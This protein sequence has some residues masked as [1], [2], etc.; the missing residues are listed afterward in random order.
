MKVIL[1]LLLSILMLTFITSCGKD[2]EAKKTDPESLTLEQRFLSVM[3]ANCYRCHANGNNSGAFGN[4]DD[5]SAMKSQGYLSAGDTNGS[6]IYQVVIENGN[7]RDPDD[8]IILSGR[9]PLNG[10]VYL[11]DED[12]ETVRQ[13]ILELE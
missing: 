3:E 11:S 7:Y 8:N 13:F 2:G 1:K 4:V 9:M 5:I 12:I 10:G 6:V